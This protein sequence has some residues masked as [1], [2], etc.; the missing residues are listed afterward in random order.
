MTCGLPAGLTWRLCTSQSPIVLQPV[1]IAITG[2]GYNNGGNSVGSGHGAG[3]ALPRFGPS[4]VSAGLEQE[5]ELGADFS[6]PDKQSLDSA[7]PG[8]QK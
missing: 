7:E 6:L 2:S 1:P 8:S 3:L 4:R 5:L